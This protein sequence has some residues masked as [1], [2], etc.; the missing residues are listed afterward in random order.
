[1]MVVMRKENIRKIRIA[2]AGNPNVGKTTLF[3]SI[4]GTRQHVGNWPGVTVE[5]KVGYRNF[6][7]H[8][9]EVVDLPGTYSL[10]AYSMDEVVARDYIIEDRPDVV[11]NIIDATNL[12]RNLY[13]TTQLMELDTKLVI[14]LN[15][16]DLL[17]SR[18]DVL[19]Q[20]KLENFLEI[21]II[22]TVGNTGE[23]IEQLLTEIIK[24]SEKGPHH[25]HVFGYGQEIE[26]II[27]SLEKIIRDYPNISERYPPRWLSIKLIEHDNEVEKQIEK[28]PKDLKIAIKDVLKNIPSEKLEL[29]MV[30]K[31]YENINKILNQVLQKREVLV[32]PSDMID[33]VLT[34]KYLGIP[35]FLAIMWGVFELT[36]TFSVPF[37]DALDFVFVEL[38]NYIADNVEPQWLAS[39]LGRGII[40][41]VGFILIFFPTIFI[42]FFILSFLEDS[43]YIARAAFIMDKLMYKIG[44]QGKSFIPLLLGFGCSVPAIM[45]TRTIEDRKDRLITIMVNP[46]ISCGARLPVY[47]LI[48][49]TFFGRQAGTVIFIIYALSILMVIIATKLLRITVIKGSPAPFIMELPPYRIPTIKTSILHMWDRGSLYLR[50][51][52]TIILGASIIIWVISSINFNGYI[53]ES[54]KD[55]DDS[56]LVADGIIEGTG[57]FQGDGIFTG[58][59]QENIT[60]VNGTELTKGESVKDLELTKDL[61]LLGNGTFQGEVTFKGN[62]SY[63][64]SDFT[65]EESFA[66]D[67]GKLA[68]PFTKPLGFNWKINTALIFGFVAKEFVVGT[69]GILYGVGEGG[70]SSE[71]G[72]LSD[73]MI[74]SGDFSPLIALCLMI[75][76]L[77]YTPCIAT[78]AVIKKETGKWRWSIFS[79]LFGFGL[80]WLMVFIVYNVGVVAGFG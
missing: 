22:K 16:Y 4:T 62:G 35:I 45:A 36:F 30:D 50:K 15:M 78:I 68:E 9:I 21:P 46:F 6:N 56:L 72:D 44:L 2:L 14:A 3:N 25:E 63:T 66:A 51:A 40:G 8:T 38:G 37:M 64:G 67:I 74:D 17:E 76:V 61:V 60:L 33:R 75:F 13:L 71:E 69:V 49:G 58:Y 11:V 26:D 73:A 39:L 19:D 32:T 53:S 55:I 31:R 27:T 12:E 54:T 43:G 29:E 52:G 42:L 79:M 59:I 65:I 24:E 28:Q 20:K 5:K 41:G 70:G 47:I 34:N 23:G 7:G 57:E 18:G 80:A 1:M 48:A 77:I 10:T